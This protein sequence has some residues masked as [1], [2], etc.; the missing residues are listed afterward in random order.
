MVDKAGFQDHTNYL[1]INSLKFPDLV[2]FQT[3]KLKYKARNKQLPDNIQ[4]H[5][6]DREGAGV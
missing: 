3:A 4:K 1:F 6:M 5:F 2:E